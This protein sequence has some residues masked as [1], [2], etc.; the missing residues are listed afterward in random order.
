MFIT[1]GGPNGTRRNRKAMN[2]KDQTLPTA[3]VSSSSEVEN[4]LRQ[5][6]VAPV[7][8]RQ[9]RGRLVFAMDAT[10]SRQPRWDEAARI[11]GD[12]FL[13]TA[14]LGGLG[15]QLV[16]YRGL[17]EC[18]ASRWVSA[19]EELLRLMRSVSCL[20][21]YT[22]IG[23]V[24]HHVL[25]ETG[26]GPVHAAVFVGDCFEEDADQVCRHAGELGVLGVPVFVFHEG[27][28]PAASRVFPQIAKLSG[29]AYCRFDANSPQQLRDLLSA[30]AV[31][32]AGGR[33]ALAE[34]GR[35]QGGMVLQLTHQLGG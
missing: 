17:D 18:R 19:P 7:P 6:A 13:E 33:K 2:G 4:F 15:V 28:D 1:M 30:V 32:A 21:G 14:R 24:L 25:T 12:M 20:G 11:Q 27:H 23:R 10:A 22:Q 5:V 16:Y 3:A 8:S 26:R 29:G 9:G 34:L 31:Y 35:R